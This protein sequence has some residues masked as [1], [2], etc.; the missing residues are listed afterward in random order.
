MAIQNFRHKALKRLF[1]RDDPRGLPPSF[2][3][4]LRDMLSAIDA[5]ESP[6][7]IGLF[8]GWRMHR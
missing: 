7:E 1:E 2:V 4:K 8:P 3:P 6:E 5:A